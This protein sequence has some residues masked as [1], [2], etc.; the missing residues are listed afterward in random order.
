M[1]WSLPH[2]V[3]HIFSSNRVVASFIFAVWHS[4]STGDRQWSLL[5][6]WGVWDI[7]G[8]EWCKTHHFSP[9]PPSHKWV[10]WEGSTNC[11]TWTKETQGSL[12]T[13]LAK[14]LTTYQSTPQS[15]TGMSLAQLLLG[16]CSR[17]RLDLFVPNT[18]EKVK[19]RQLQPKVCHDKLT[20]RK[21]F[22]RGHKVYVRNFGTSSGQKWLPA[23]IIEVTDPVSFMVRLHDNR[24]VRH[25]VDHVRPN[26]ERDNHSVRRST[27]ES[28]DDILIEVP[29]TQSETPEADPGDDSNVPQLTEPA[30]GG[31]P[32]NNN[33]HPAKNPSNGD[34]SIGAD[35]VSNAPP[36]NAGSSTNSTEAK[37]YPKRNHHPPD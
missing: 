12:K 35:Q 23:V 9:I 5:C 20:P 31:T 4:R 27:W 26:G 34:N 15:T 11:K 14:I 1:D 33:Y 7:L 28:E 29:I 19:H 8:K 37:S 21:S 13:W 22:K 2:G 24:L 18:S 16:R 3:C 6:Q 36:G 10:G 25:N 32:G 30:R 17:T